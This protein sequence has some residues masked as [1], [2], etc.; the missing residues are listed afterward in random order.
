MMVSQNPMGNSL[1]EFHVK[2]TACV[3][4]VAT[5]LNLSHG[6]EVFTQIWAWQS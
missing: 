6:C 4:D 2:K 5:H 3:L 1:S